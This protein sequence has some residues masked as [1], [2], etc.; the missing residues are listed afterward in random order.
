VGKRSKSIERNVGFEADDNYINSIVGEGTHFRGHL[1][2][3]G[4]LRIDGDFSGSIATS[5]K[6][7]VGKNG[8]ADCTIEADTVVVGGI[9]RGAIYATQK[10][11]VL[12]SALILGNIQAPRLIAEEGV[13]IDGVLAIREAPAR[14][15]A[16]EGGDR[17]AVLTG[18]ALDSGHK[19]SLAGTRQAGL[20]QA[21]GTPK[22]GR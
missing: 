16:N 10:V 5:G 12:S 21:V 20:E 22:G 19:Q 13:L 14:G 11:I 8:R 17:S 18:H 9:L 4:L 15:G 7:L 6:V 3:S 1:Q 2:L